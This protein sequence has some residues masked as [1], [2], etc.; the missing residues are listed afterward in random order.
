M[1]RS[2]RMVAM[3]GLELKRMIAPVMVA[4]LLCSQVVAAFPCSC[5]CSQ[6]RDGVAEQHTRLATKSCC[7]PCCSTKAAE[8]QRC[9]SAGKDSVSC[10]CNS[11]LPSQHDSPSHEIETCS[12]ES[13][14]LPF[15]TAFAILAAGQI[16]PPNFDHMECAEG[17]SR[18]IRFCIWLI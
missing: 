13:V 1:P 12:L 2:V 5:C 17:V 18:Q 10:D 4:A 3:F 8:D 6:R 9:C 11:G 14:C 7:A 16:Q 15:S